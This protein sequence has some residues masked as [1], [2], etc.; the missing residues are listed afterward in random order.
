MFASDNV[1]LPMPFAQIVGGTM[2]GCL[3]VWAR[4]DLTL[5]FRQE[6]AHAG[7]ISTLA[8]DKYEH[9]PM[10]MSGGADGIVKVRE[11]SLRRCVCLH[12]ALMFSSASVVS[13]RRQF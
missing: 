5:L 12:A 11:S 9:M 6:K 1:G 10:L 7:P 4:S 2:W 8:F 3:Y 13:A